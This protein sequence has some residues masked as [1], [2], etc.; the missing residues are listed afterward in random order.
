M[1]LLEDINVTR[2]FVPRALYAHAEC[3]YATASA[4]FLQLRRSAVQEKYAKH[5]LI[6]DKTSVND[7][8]A[9]C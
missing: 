3:P 7:V 4:L 6:S 9:G 5:A 2:I 8:V 1:Y